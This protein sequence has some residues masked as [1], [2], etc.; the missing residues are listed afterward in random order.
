MNSMKVD[1]ETRRLWAEKTFELINI[2]AGALLFGRVLS[3]RGFSPAEALGGLFL[4]A[5]GYILSYIL[6]KRK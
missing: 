1:K 6:L 4:V 5:I 2:G 3:G